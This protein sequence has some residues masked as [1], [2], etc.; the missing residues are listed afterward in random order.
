[1]RYLLLSDIHANA[2]A[3]EAVLQHA[4]HKSWDEVV[5]LG[6]AV[7]Y[8]TEPQRVV[9]QL[10]ELNPSVCI[11][12][13]HD[14]MLIDIL[15]GVAS[16]SKEDGVVREVLARHVQ[17]M[18]A[19]AIDFV[20]GFGVHYAGDGW[21]AT[22][23]ALRSQWE[24]LS[25][26]QN[27]QG[28]LAFLTQRICLI[29]HTHVPKIFA[30]VETPT[31]EIW[32]TVP[33]RKDQTTYRIPPRARLFFNPGSVGQPR[34][35]IPLASYAIFDNDTLSVELFRVEYD[36]LAV[37]REVREHGYPEVLASRLAVGR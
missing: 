21:E 5:F 10:V 19:A 32:R 2:H 4:K 6:D 22:H 3:L 25:T 27:A 31:G 16:D 34:D 30:A 20:R 23:G 24:Y 35:G 8:Y 33:F 7:G 14:A 37:Q 9:E 36:L 15:D 29:G 17:E 12:G 13:N 28:N 26:L 18:S 1:M 11:L